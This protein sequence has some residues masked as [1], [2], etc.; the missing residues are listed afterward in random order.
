MPD[1]ACTSAIP[2]PF[3]S[4]PISHFGT[5]PFLFATFEKHHF[6]LSPSQQTSKH[7]LFDTFERFPTFR[8]DPLE[9]L[10]PQPPLFQVP[11]SSLANH[12]FLIATRKLL[13]IELTRSVSNEKT[14]SNRC[15][16]SHFRVRAA[17]HDSRITIHESPP[18]PNHVPGSVRATSARRTTRRS[19]PGKF[20]AT[21]A[22]AAICRRQTAH[23][24]P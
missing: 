12:E 18:Q 15:Y 22:A 5:P 11:P 7:F 16:L 4:I 14:F 3:L 23:C 8:L 6:C 19:P 17:P 10:L 24:K 2:A 21:I 13:E 9:R 20:P 1:A